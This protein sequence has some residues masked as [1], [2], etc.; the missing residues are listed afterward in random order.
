VQTFGQLLTGSNAD[1]RLGSVRVDCEKPRPLTATSY[2][3]RSECGRSHRAV[4]LAGKANFNLKMTQHCRLVFW[5][6]MALQVHRVVE[7]P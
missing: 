5:G 6:Q 3:V 7:N 4:S 2:L 1:G